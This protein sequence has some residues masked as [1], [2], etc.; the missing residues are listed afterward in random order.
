MKFEWMGWVKFKSIV[1]VPGSRTLG[2]GRGM[3]DWRVSLA[4]MVIHTSSS[5]LV[6]ANDDFMLGCMHCT[7]VR[8]YVVIIR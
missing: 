4:R 6:V 7:Y 2:L 5:V 8:T 1:Y 3:L